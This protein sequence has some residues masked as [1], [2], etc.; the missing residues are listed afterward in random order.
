MIPTS[1][2]LG[3]HPQARKACSSSGRSFSTVNGWHTYAVLL[4]L[5][6]CENPHQ[7]ST[8]GLMPLVARPQSAHLKTG[9]PP[10]VIPAPVTQRKIR[11]PHALQR[12]SSSSQVC[13][14]RIFFLRFFRL[15]S[16]PS[17]HRTACAAGDL[18]V[19]FHF[20]AHRRSSSRTTSGRFSPVLTAFASAD[21]S[22]SDGIR[23]RKTGEAPRAPLRLVGPLPG[24]VFVCSVTCGQKSGW[25]PERRRAGRQS[26]SD[27]AAS[28]AFHSY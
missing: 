11:P 8:S 13:L 16:N 22:S 10:G 12:W 28:S 27:S 17:V 15:R 4:W 9:L 26:Q 18:G 19:M 3:S 25:F 14:S 1:P 21:S 5:P 7:Q 6:R 2:R 23:T 20:R 24:P